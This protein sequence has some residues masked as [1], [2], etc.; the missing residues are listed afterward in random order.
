MGAAS[1]IAE[2]IF[3]VKALKDRMIPAT[4]NY[5][6]TEKE[7][8]E[9]EIPKLHQPC[10]KGAFLSVSNGIGGQSSSVVVESIPL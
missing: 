2:V 3:G 9:L 6:S 7:F 5:D 4:L 8:S 10:T 1:D